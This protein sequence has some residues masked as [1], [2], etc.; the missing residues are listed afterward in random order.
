VKFCER[1]LPTVIRIGVI[2]YGYWGP[3][4]VRNFSDNPDCRV[5]TICDSNPHRLALAERRYP[6]VK[7]TTDATELISSADVDAV[8]IATPVHTHFELSCRT[9]N[10][11]KHVLIEK[12]LTSSSEEAEVL[13]EE[14]AKRRLVLMVDHTFLYTG[15][16]RKIKELIDA[17]DLGDICYYDSVRVNLGMFQPDVS[18]VWDLAVHDVAIMDYL[19]AAAP[20][21]VS[22]TGISNP[23]GLSQSIGYLTCF[24]EDNRIGHIH[25]NWMAPV[26]IRRTLLGGSRKMVVYD[27]VEP[28]EKVK[29]YDK[30]ISVSDNPDAVY[31]K[32]IQYRM[33]DMH[34]PQL[35]TR[36]A[37]NAE[38]IDFV[39]C[40]QHGA[41]P[42]SDGASGLRVVRILEAATESMRERGRPVE[43][44]TRRMLS[45]SLSRLTGAVS[46]DTG[47][48][49]NSHRLCSEFQ[50]VRPR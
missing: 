39:R 28:S 22:A 7:I 6:G 48:N 24:F 43:I 49:K 9:L 30:G 10:A 16:V 44:S 45:D 25:V 32:M 18:V 14:A 12:P 35:D 31:Q 17:G 46:D 1:R 42:L 37:L 29:I 47:R 20:T 38:V 34:A 23:V 40:I 19:L 4:L 13:I 21:A 8:V 5:T 26:K 36:E 27:D 3:N 33:G 2:G 41:T 11:G 50:P 15:A